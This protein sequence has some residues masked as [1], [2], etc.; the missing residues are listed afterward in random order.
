MF[1]CQDFKI[2][3]DLTFCCRACPDSVKDQN[4][5]LCFEAPCLPLSTL[6]AAH[7][8]RGPAFPPARGALPLPLPL[9]PSPAGPPPAAAS[10]APR[11]PTPQ[12]ENSGEVPAPPEPGSAT[13]TAGH[14][15]GAPNSRPRGRT[16]ARP[17]RPAGRCRDSR[18]G[19]DTPAAPIRSP[20]SY[21]PWAPTPAPRPGSEAPVFP[22]EEALS[23]RL[24]VSGRL[25]PAPA[26]PGPWP[27]PC[28]AKRV[29][30]WPLSPIPHA[31]PSPGVAKRR[32]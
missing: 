9:S 10:T 20:R 30:D 28:P 1:H 19:A 7:P 8:G 3:I 18:V 14:R 5:E 13:T 2:K 25:R 17:S 22:S 21:L 23:P 32:R 4:T 12:P 15:R 29:S 16:P 26:G 31:R 11:P 6:K 27:R 24:S